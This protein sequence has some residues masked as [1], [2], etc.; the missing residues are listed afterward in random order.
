MHHTVS[1]FFSQSDLERIKSAVH[2]AESKTSGEI[3]PYVVDHSD[4]YEEA[5][6]RG[7][8]LLSS[9]ILVLFVFL[10]GNLEW[11]FALTFGQM[12]S[13][14]LFAGVVGF[15]L[16]KWSPALKRFLAGHR[17]IEHHIGHRAAAAFL[18]EEVFK[19]RDRTGIL[20]FVSLLEHRVIVMGDSGIN[21]KV[22]HE[23]WNGIVQTLVRKI[24]E[25][26]P[27]DG[28]VEAIRMSGTLLEQH[29]LERR[30]DDSDELPDSLR[31]SDH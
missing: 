6:W 20:I 21:V 2:E 8:A 13:L 15:F 16:V 17:T 1:R 5:Q 12:A 29:H 19:T 9:L 24:R 22:K 18:S 11:G 14:V 28:F 30:K 7:A 31:M 3:V 10:H 25:G 23:D 4:A 26:K 27:A